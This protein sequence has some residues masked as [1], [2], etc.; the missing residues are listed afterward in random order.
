MKISTNYSSLFVENSKKIRAVYNSF[1]EEY[2]HS[3]IGTMTEEMEKVDMLLLNSRIEAVRSKIHRK[4][5]SQKTE[6]LNHLFQTSLLALYEVEK[7]WIYKGEINQKEW[8]L[9]FGTGML[10]TL[11]PR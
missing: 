4:H 3:V 8:I 9:R 11:V 6:T 7:E 5:F 1:T 10:G 2:I